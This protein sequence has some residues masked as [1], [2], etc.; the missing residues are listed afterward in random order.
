MSTRQIAFRY[1]SACYKTITVLLSES[2]MT[3]VIFF[4]YEMFEFM[5]V[6]VF[7]DG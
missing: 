5:C 3:I 2:R 6:G 1:L 7:F 4:N